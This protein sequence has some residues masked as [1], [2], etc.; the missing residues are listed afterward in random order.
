MEKK[1]AIRIFETTGALQNGHFLLTSGLH[2]PQYFQCALVLQYPHYLEQFCYD[3]FDFYHDE[4]DI[5][6][7][8]A[9]AVGGIVVANTLARMFKSRAIFTE[10]EQGKM[11]FRRGFKIESHE[12]V[13]LC[14]DVITTGGSVQEV[15]DLV[16]NI[17]AYP[18]GIGAIL[19]RSGGS[20]SF[21]IPFFATVQTKTVTYKP[22]KCPLCRQKIPLI[23]PGSRDLPQV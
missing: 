14:E 5:D 21:E 23:K 13:L 17:G 8:V 2:S 15:L 1:E 4:N 22:D 16:E 19:D 20:C 12:K 6:V 11:L 7:I 18:V 3:I 9:P 10:R